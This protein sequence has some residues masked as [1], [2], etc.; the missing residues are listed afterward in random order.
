MVNASWSGIA[1]II[2]V[3]GALGSLWGCIWRDE[4]RPWLTFYGALFGMTVYYIMFHFVWRRINPLM[5][6]YAP[7]R[8]L[9][10]GHLIWGMILA[11]SPRYARSIAARVGPVT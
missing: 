5:F 3:Y 1:L 8:Q 11:R 6:L 7:D 2:A 4:P 9:E 10:V